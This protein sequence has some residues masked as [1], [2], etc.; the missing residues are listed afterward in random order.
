MSMGTPISPLFTDLYELTM[1]AAYWEQGKNEKATFSLYLRPQDSRGY[2]VAAGLE[3]ALTL[4]E[5]F[6]FTPDDIAYL[7]HLGLFKP[8]LLAYLQNLRFEGEV[9]ALSE[10][11]LFFP[12][13]PVL[14][15]T[16]PLIQAQL[17]ETVLINMIGVHTLI[18]S[19][20]ARCVHAA[21]GRQ[22]ID[23]ALR[24]TQGVDAGMAVARST[25]LAGFNATS[26]VLAGKQLGIPLA[27]TMAHSFIQSFADETEAFEVYAGIFP[28]NTVLLIDTYDTLAG[29]KKA[30]EVGR[31][32]AASGKRLIGVR[33]DSGDMVAQSREVRRM[34]DDAGLSDV[35]IF[36][37]GGFD[38]F[39]VSDAL[40]RDAFID[41]FGVGTH[42]GVSADQPFLDLVYKLVRYKNRDICKLSAGKKTLAA[43]KQIFRF[44]DETGAFVEDIIGHRGEDLPGGEKLLHRVMENG[45][46][47]RKIPALEEIRRRFRS[48][49]A[50]LPE[51][52]KQLNAPPRYTVRLSDG[53]INKQPKD[54]MLL[55]Q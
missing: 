16:A 33:L 24:R 7:R 6:R 23:F 52:Y 44:K 37:S 11:T 51:T 41:A 19:K 2:Y 13:E 5:Q 45:R 36:A 8:D 10:G 22:L 17:L 43:P 27:G 49:F 50:S 55:P 12:D 47:C 14:E 42:M 38:E 39:M 18:A 26:N 20:A 32:M 30:V 9:R 48:Q 3:P 1:A 46:T 15:V 21:K 28:E 29:A 40:E 25:Y 35:Q 31:R 4:L 53:L 34:F 54:F